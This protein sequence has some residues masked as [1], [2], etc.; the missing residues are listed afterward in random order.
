MFWRGSVPVLSDAVVIFFSSMVTLTPN[1]S[2]WVVSVLHSV[3]DIINEAPLLSQ[4]FI[5]TP[6]DC[7]WW[8]YLTTPQLIILPNNWTLIYKCICCILCVLFLLLCVF[9]VFMCIC[10]TLMCICCTYV[11]L[12]YLM[13]ICCTMCV[14]LYLRCICCTMCVLLFLL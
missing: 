5:R 7:R 10:C 1:G 6:G 14:L 3:S 12:L 2:C 11:Y 9:V 8:H 13:C 4:P